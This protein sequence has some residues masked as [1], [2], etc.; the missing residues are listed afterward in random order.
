MTV[1]KRLRHRLEYLAFLAFAGLTRAL[2]LD[3]ASRV[4][5][6]AWRLVAPRLRRHRRAIANLRQA[7]PEKSRA[8]IERIALGMWDNLGRTFAEFFH[9]AEII[10]TGRIVIENPEHFE[11]M[12]ARRG[13][14]VACSLHM[15]N[16]EIASQVGLPLGWRPAGVYQRIAN[17]H[18][19]RYVNAIR[20]PLYPGGLRE[21]SAEAA[22]AM[23]RYARE[24]GCTA[25]LADQ[26]DSR[27]IPAPFFGRP[28]F[29]TVFPALVARSLDAPL[30]VFR[31]KRLTGVR[32]S[33]RVVDVPVPRTARRD[34]DVAA[35]T[36]AL[37]A[38][39]EA[40]IREAPEQWM[41]AQR[42]WD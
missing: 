8:E 26:R 17:P 13:G 38:V 30:H 27:G 21:K 24:G 20:A 5:G 39:L 32:F 11:A 29:S 23:L 1:V 12:R 4:S 40:M 2:P 16:W 42:R 9:I 22:R 14:V 6:A 3:I 18:V 15:A 35:A 41:W 10:D 34:D 19:E 36:R 31:I 33:V 28:A 37:Q 25:L 7:Y